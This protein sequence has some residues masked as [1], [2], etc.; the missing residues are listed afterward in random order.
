MK[1]TPLT[2]ALFRKYKNIVQNGEMA[3]RRLLDVVSPIINATDGSITAKQRD[4]LL[5]D[6]HRTLAQLVALIEA[7]E[8]KR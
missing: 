4:E 8:R 2:Q 1:H 6:A 5:H 7:L 3:S